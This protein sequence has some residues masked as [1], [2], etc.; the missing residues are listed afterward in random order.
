[1][2]TQG[3][4]STWGFLGGSDGRVCL[5]CKRPGFD[6]W[7]GKVPWRRE[8]LPFSSHRCPGP[9][10]PEAPGA[11]PPCP[12]FTSWLPWLSPLDVICFFCRIWKYLEDAWRVE[13]RGSIAVFL[14]PSSRDPGKRGEAWETSRNGMRLWVLSSRVGCLNLC[15]NLCQVRPACSAIQYSWIPKVS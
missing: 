6:P 5:Q 2:P 10:T 13:L 11:A 4:I 9:Q 15:P 7:V 14:H 8:W 12:L 1:M 3:R